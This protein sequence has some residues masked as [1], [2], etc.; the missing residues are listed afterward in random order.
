MEYRYRYN[1]IERVDDLGLN[2]DMAA[3]RS[4]DPAI[5]RWGQVDPLGEVMTSWSAYAR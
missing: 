2:W 3:F 4:Y 1:G 5:A